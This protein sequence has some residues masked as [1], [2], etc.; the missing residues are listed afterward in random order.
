MNSGFLSGVSGI[1][2]DVGNVGIIDITR[3]T[4]T[5]GSGVLG[6]VGDRGMVSNPSFCG[7]TSTSGGIMTYSSALSRDVV[8]FNRAV[9]SIPRVV[10]SEGNVSASTGLA[11]STSAS[12]IG[13]R[14]VH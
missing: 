9:G 7:A 11:L 2:A 12:G 14:E 8:G 3:E 6:S 4:T 1:T 10:N 13:R 5:G